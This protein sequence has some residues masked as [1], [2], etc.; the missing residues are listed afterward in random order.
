MKIETRIIDGEAWA[1]V[2]PGYAVL[3]LWASVDMFMR[4]GGVAISNC[5]K[6]AE[7][8]IGDTA[9]REAWTEWS[10]SR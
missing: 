4:G 7:G 6:A 9:A 3:P 2:P 8:G 5:G 1:K 10:R